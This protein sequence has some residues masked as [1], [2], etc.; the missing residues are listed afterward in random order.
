MRRTHKLSPQAQARLKA[1]EVTAQLN[2]RQ[3]LT[4]FWQENR[5]FDIGPPPPQEMT[6][7]EKG[8]YQ[9]TVPI[10]PAWAIAFL[11]YAVLIFRELADGYFRITESGKDFDRALETIV[12]PKVVSQVG[13]PVFW[14][15]ILGETRKE[16]GIVVPPHF[17]SQFNLPEVWVSEAIRKSASEWQARAWQREADSATQP[18]ARGRLRAA[19]LPAKVQEPASSSRYNTREQR[20]AAIERYKARWKCT[21]KTLADNARVDPSDLNKWKLLKLKGTSE[22]GPRIAE[23]LKSNTPPKDPPPKDRLYRR[24]SPSPRPY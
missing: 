20:T 21:L 15:R 16:L 3:K 9:T 19:A 5:E 7:Y 8:V 17:T 11:E 13:A 24:Y 23:L 22:K 14:G 2:L 10:K 6:S 4:R 1:V 18:V 12:I